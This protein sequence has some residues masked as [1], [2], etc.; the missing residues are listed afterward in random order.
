VLRVLLVDDDHRLRLAMA[1][2]LRWADCEI[3]E[4][5]DGRQALEILSEDA[6][7][8][9]I[10]SDIRMPR[11]DGI[12]LL[13]A[14]RRYYPRIQLVMLSMYSNEAW[15]VEAIQQRAVRYLPKPFSK[16]QLVNAVYDAAK[17][18]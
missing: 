18:Q 6:K 7:F 8:D 15:T 14:V 13:E 1:Q 12:H 9:V 16:Q 11:L 3:V 4:A 2:A 17:V 5:G 10:L